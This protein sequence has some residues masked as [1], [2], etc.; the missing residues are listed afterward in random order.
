MN[1]RLT[2][3]EAARYVGQWDSK[4]AYHE[5]ATGQTMPW[6]GEGN[7]VLPWRRPSD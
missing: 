3:T 5:S 2:G 7:G 4:P 6:A 1:S